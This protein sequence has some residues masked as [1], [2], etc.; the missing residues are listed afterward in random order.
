LIALSGF[1]SPHGAIQ[2]SDERGR[3]RLC[4]RAFAESLGC[5]LKLWAEPVRDDV[6]LELRPGE[7]VA[8]VGRDGAGKSTLLCCLGGWTSVEGG[9]ISTVGIPI[10]RAEREI[11]RHIALIPNVPWFHEESIAWEHLHSFG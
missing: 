2:G 5:E 9:E 1:R 11:E 3:E 10:G 8:L 4:R 6:S 7:L